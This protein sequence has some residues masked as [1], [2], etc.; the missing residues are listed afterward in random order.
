VAPA[1]VQ[2]GHAVDILLDAG[3][4]C[5]VWKG[6]LLFPYFTMTWLEEGSPC[7]PTGRVDNF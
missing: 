3:A 7:T 4:Y 6:R 2:A 5:A 1:P